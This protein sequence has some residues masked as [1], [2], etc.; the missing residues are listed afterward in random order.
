MSMLCI[1]DFRT[2]LTLLAFLKKIIIVFALFSEVLFCSVWLG[3]GG[4]KV[5]LIFSL[6]AEL[7]WV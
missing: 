3:R 5:I 1:V 2:L 7:P 6:F 4:G